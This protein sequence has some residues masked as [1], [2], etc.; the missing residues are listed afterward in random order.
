MEAMGMNQVKKLQDV[1]LSVF[2]PFHLNM[3]IK[4]M[5]HEY[6]ICKTEARG[7]DQEK[8]FNTADV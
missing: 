4:L 6:E 1:T 8:H 5:V 7:M 3:T 2:L